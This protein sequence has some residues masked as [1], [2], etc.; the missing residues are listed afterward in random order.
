MNSPSSPNAITS[1][2]PAR[3]LQ[4]RSAMKQHGIDATI[5]PSADPHLSEYLPDRWQGR[6]YFSGFTGSVGTLIVTAD[7]A[8]LWVD[9]RYWS[10]AEKELAP[11][12]IQMMKI[13]SAGSTAHIDWLT[14]SLQA[15]QT[16]GVD[17]MVLGLMT[18]RLLDQNLKAKAIQLKTNID[19]LQE[20]WT[21]RPGLPS[22]PIFEHLAPFAVI[23]RQEKLALV[24]EQMRV[25]GTEWHFVSTVDDLAWIFNLRG[26][27]VSY[28]PVFAG[29]ALIGMN[30]ATIFVADE[31]IPPALQTILAQD[32]VK[33]ASYNNAADTLTA[34]PANS[35]ILIDPRRITLGFQQAIPAGMR[36]VDSINP[37][38]L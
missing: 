36:V 24:R 14:E 16:V 20:I 34:L 1:P 18:A 25:K 8:G 10:Q 38:V 12:G 19:L 6:S 7:F 22:S 33:I 27:D 32:Q 4:L 3:L 11:T 29:H 30:D 37:S 17:G 21:D 2:I 31:K 28:N 9:S 35:S 5:I 15:G 23:S 13:A 26:S